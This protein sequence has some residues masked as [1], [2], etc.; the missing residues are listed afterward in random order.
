LAG[1]STLEAG[2]NPEYQPATRFP[3]EKNKA[4][5]KMMHAQPHLARDYPDFFRTEPRNWR[6]D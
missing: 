6:E 2:F 1:A 3:P 4:L 5:R